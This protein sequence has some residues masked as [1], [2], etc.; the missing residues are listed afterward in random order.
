[1]PTSRLDLAY[2]RQGGRI[3]PYGEDRRFFAGQTVRVREAANGHAPFARNA[4][5]TVEQTLPGGRVRIS[6]K[7]GGED[8]YAE[9]IVPTSMI[10]PVH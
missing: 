10:R 9:L 4:D 1:M 8:S 5:V 7:P 2:G 6:W 3:V